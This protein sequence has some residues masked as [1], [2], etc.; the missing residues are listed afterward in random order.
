MNW[1]LITLLPHCKITE[2]YGVLHVAS[3]IEKNT[4][5]GEELMIFCQQINFN[6]KNCHNKV[7]ELPTRKKITWT[8]QFNAWIPDRVSEAPG[9]K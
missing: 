4:F 5:S 3:K 8:R 1:N 9:V 7:E 6:R 2:H